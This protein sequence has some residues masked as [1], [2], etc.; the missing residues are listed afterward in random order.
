MTTLNS[1]ANFPLE[2]NDTNQYRNVDFCSNQHLLEGR[3]FQFLEAL[4]LKTSQFQD[5]ILVEYINVGPF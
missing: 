4:F 2:E 3:D 5:R 1:A